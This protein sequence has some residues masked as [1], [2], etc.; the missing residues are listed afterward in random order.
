MAVTVTV[1]PGPEFERTRKELLKQAAE[2]RKRVSKAAK[3]VVDDIYLPGVRSML[4]E[5][6]PSG[7]VPV[8]APDLRVR[9]IVRASGGV[10]AVLSA[11][12][13]GPKG[14]DLM[15]K[16]RGDLRHPDIRDL[17]PRRKGRA[18]WRW[19]GQRIPRG[20]ASKPLKTLRPRIVKALDAELERIAH[21]V[22]RS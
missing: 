1:V 4:P 15:Q 8:L 11:P 21:D 7:Y 12:T 20:F 16:E 5:F 22:K 14:R 9:T 17:S 3:D 13:G 2:L 18:E 6:F 19:H 10:T